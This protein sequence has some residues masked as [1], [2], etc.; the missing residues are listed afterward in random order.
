MRLLA[1]FQSC[2]SA[3]LGQATLYWHHAISL[4]KALGV[5]TE[6][7]LSLL[8][9]MCVQNGGV[10]KVIQDEVKR[11]TSHEHKLRALAQSV[12]DGKWDTADYPRK[13]LIANG[14]GSIYGM[15][16]NIENQYGIRKDVPHGQF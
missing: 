7:G 13:I 2:K 1:N 15:D 4:A 14:A 9:D 11:I 12:R 3:Q 6:R 10:K 16:I 5:T 8:F